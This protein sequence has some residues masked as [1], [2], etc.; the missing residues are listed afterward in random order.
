M[1]E[2]MKGEANTN[3]D[4]KLTVGELGDYIHEN[5][6]IWQACWTGNKPPGWRP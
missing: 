5:V 2:G 3:G 4:K 6:P 1:S